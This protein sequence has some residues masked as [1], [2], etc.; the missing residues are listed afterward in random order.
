[1]NIGRGFVVLAVLSGLVAGC[2]TSSAPDGIAPNLPVTS[3]PAPSPAPSPAPV[4]GP[5]VVLPPA[6]VDNTAEGMDPTQP[7]AKTVKLWY[8]TNRKPTQPFLMSNPFGSE[9]DTKLNY[10]VAE[11]FI[12]KSHETGS[13][14][15]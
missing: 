9:R 14:G 15:S 13:L 10:G 8:G 4:P 11:V 3:P 1:M 5:V 12:P 7:R 6:P 2:A